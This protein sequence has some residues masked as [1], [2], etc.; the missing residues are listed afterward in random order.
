MKVSK[1]QLRQ[2]IRE[3]KL[4]QE[5]AEIPTVEV[6][7]EGGTLV[8][9]PDTASEVE[10]V[11]AQAFDVLDDLVL[12]IEEGGYPR[13]SRQV[14]ID[15]RLEQLKEQLEVAVEGLYNAQ[16]QANHIIAGTGG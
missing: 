2:I 14:A 3:E 1:N 10:A 6:T 15:P 16:M 4:L 13:S 12:A 11:I 9:S 7:D 8:I 5:Q